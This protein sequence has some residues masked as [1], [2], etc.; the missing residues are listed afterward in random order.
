[1]ELSAGNLLL[2]FCLCAEGVLW[3]NSAEG[4]SVIS[5]I[6]QLIVS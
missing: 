3:I 4:A 6:L 2:I 1:M 5:A